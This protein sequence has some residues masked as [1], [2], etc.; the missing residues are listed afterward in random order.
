MKIQQNSEKKT[1]RLSQTVYTQA[2]LKQFSMTNTHFIL[3]LMISDFSNQNVTDDKDNNLFNSEKY[4]F[5]VKSL[6]FLTNYIKSDIFFIT[7]YLTCMNSAL[8][9]TH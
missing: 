3:T 9:V 8:T 1:I 4:R 7:D 6:Q 2:L 5:A